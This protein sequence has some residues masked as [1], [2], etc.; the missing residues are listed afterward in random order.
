MNLFQL[1]ETCASFGVSI[2]D[3]A[4]LGLLDSQSNVDHIHE[5]Q[6]DMLP[7]LITRL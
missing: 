7:T 6:N 1:W 2:G 5:P 4:V 3:I